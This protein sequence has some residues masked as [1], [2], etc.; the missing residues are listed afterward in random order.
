M[1]DQTVVD[2]IREIAGMSDD[3]EERLWGSEAVWC[4][5]C[6]MDRYKDGEEHKPTCVW[7]RSVAFLESVDA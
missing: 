4:V 2:L 3:D 7:V 6:G 5:F 1:H